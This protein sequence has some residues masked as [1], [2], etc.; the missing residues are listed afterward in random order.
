[1]WAVWTLLL[2]WAD[3]SGHGWFLVCLVARLCFVLRLLATNRQ[4]WVMRQLTVDPQVFWDYC[5]PSNMWS[6]VL[7]WVV[8]RP[9]GV[10]GLVLTQWWAEKG[11]KGSWA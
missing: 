1:M 10:P 4:Y 11:S 8:A 6:W 9:W 5:W 3:Y 2:W 7:G